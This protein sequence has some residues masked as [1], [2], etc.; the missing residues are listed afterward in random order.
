MITQTPLSVR[1]SDFVKDDLDKFCY[2]AAAPRNRVI[3]RAVKEYIQ[4]LEIFA[5]CACT[6]QDYRADDS[7]MRWCENA[8]KRRNDWWYI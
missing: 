6:G 2:S 4:L 3:N 7:F 5:R 8:N 1:M